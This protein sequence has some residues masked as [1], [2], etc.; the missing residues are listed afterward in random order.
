MNFNFKKEISING[1]RNPKCIEYDNKIII[2]GSKV[3]Y[4]NDKIKKYLLYKYFLDENFNI[5]NNSENVLNFSNIQFD[6]FDNTNISSWIRD[7]YIDNNEYKLLIEL[8]KNNDNKFFSSV[9]YILKTTDFIK[10]DI[11]NKYEISDL[12]FKYYNNNYFIS[13]IENNDHIWGKYLFEFIIN[14]EKIIPSFDKIINYEKDYGHIL[15][16]LKYDENTKLYYIIFSIRYYSDK[17]ENNFYYKIYE[18][19]S[20]DLINYYDTKEINLI[21]NDEIKS[22]WFC[23][24]FKFKFRNN[25]YLILNQDDFGKNKFPLLFIK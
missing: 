1:I 2:I 6:Y 20:K 14:G 5:I 23:Y 25:E 9:H 16:H 8:K 4:E 7:L 3:Y 13:K 22:K 21:I 10:F 12:F 11:V 19:Y 17:E 15:H 24:P 18:A